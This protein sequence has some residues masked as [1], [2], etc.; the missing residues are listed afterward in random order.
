MPNPSQIANWFQHYGLNLACIIFGCINWVVQARRKEIPLFHRILVRE[1][2]NGAA[3][4]PILILMA[5]SLAFS[6]L[7]YLEHSD[8]LVLFS[9]GLFAIFALVDTSFGPFRKRRRQAP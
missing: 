8:G 3:V 1:W 6:V 7:A 5:G 2:V 4:P 9:S